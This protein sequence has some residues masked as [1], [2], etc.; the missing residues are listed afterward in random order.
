MVR[1]KNVSSN[2]SGSYREFTKWT[3]Q[4]DLILL[5]AMID[6]VRK[7]CRIDG[8]WTTQG[9]TN[10]KSLKDRWREIHY[11]FGGLSGFA[12]NQT[13][14]LFEAEDE[15]WSELIKAKPSAAKWPFNPIRHYDLMEELWS[16]DR[17]T[18]SRVRT[19]RD[20]NSPPNMTNFSVNLGENSMDYIPEQ[21]NFEEADDYVPRSPAPQ[22]Q[23]SNTPSDTPSNAPSMPSAGS[24]GTSSSRGSM[25]K[26]PTMDDIDEQFAML[27]TNLQQCVSSMK[28]GNENA[29]QLVNIARAQATKTQD[30]AVEI[31]RRNDLY[32]EHVHHHR[33]HASYQ[34]SKSDIWAMLVELNIQD[35]QLMDQCYEFLCDHPG[36]G[37]SPA[38][39]VDVPPP[40]MR[41]PEVLDYSRYFSTRRQMV[42]FEKN[43]HARA[44]LLQKVMYTP[45]F[46]GPGFEFQNLLNWQGLQPFLGI[47]L[48]YYEDLVRVFYP[49]AKITPV[50]HLAIEI[51]GKIIH[52]KEID[53]MTIAHLQYDSLK[54]TLG[55]IPEE[56][57]FDRALAL[58]SMIREEVEGE[59]LKNVGSL[60]MNDRLLHYTWMHIL[61][62]RGSNYAQLLN[63]DIF[64]LWLIKNN[65][66]INWP[67]YIMQHIIKCRD[68]K[69]SLPYA[70]LITRILQVYGFDLSNEQK[71]MLGWNHY[72]GKKS[73]TKLNIFQVNGI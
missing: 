10:I 11:L 44:V 52:I 70:N 41:I 32:A 9:Y 2:S 31:R 45:F 69:M 7:G 17:A 20:I 55:T 62:P 60:K 43:F 49:N 56:L 61:C 68:N 27:N 29:S 64:M 57:N 12:W 47:N 4:M 28:D 35:E 65:V 23:S 24:A 48:P 26:D 22:F 36:R 14:K 5:N 6:E 15:V 73:M 30:I 1:G 50:G 16:N 46:A 13:T 25:R 42:V 67:H 40:A 3:M 34:Y 38:E 21:P 33:R 51:C 59:N 72:F 37:K 71:I 19:A 53:W 58:S 63:E 66:R 8:S 18:G 54:L 39:D